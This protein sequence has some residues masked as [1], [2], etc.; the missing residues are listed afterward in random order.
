MVQRI[1]VEHGFE[2]EESVEFNGRRALEI[3]AADSLGF[4]GGRV[5]ETEVDRWSILLDTTEGH[6]RSRDTSLS[7]VLHC[8]F[9]RPSHKVMVKRPYGS[10]AVRS[11]TAI[12]VVDPEA[13]WARN[14]FSRVAVELTRLDPALNLRPVDLLQVGLIRQRRYKRTILH[15]SGVPVYISFDAVTAFDAEGKLALG[16]R[17]WAEAEVIDG[18]PEE[19]M[20]AAQPR[21]VMDYLCTQHGAV[22][23]SASKR[24]WAV[25]LLQSAQWGQPQRASTSVV[26]LSTVSTRAPAASYAAFLRKVVPVGL[27]E[28]PDGPHSYNA[29][30][31]VRDDNFR[32]R[33]HSAHYTV[34]RQHS[35]QAL[36]LLSS[37][38]DQPAVVPMRRAFRTT[39][40]SSAMLRTT[41][42][43]CQRVQPAL[44]AHHAA[45]RHQFAGVYTLA[46]VQVSAYDTAK[47]I[48]F[49]RSREDTIITLDRYFETGRARELFTDG[50]VD[51][52]SGSAH[53]AANTIVGDDGRGW[54]SIPWADTATSTFTLVHECMHALHIDANP[55]YGQL[56]T[57]LRESIA[58]IAEFE[59]FETMEPQHRREQTL[60]R[61]RSQFFRPMYQ[62]AFEID[63]RDNTI[64]RDTEAMRA[65]Y[66]RR[67]SDAYGAAVHISPDDG[68]EWV[69]GRHL[70]RPFALI[71]YATSFLLGALLHTHLNASGDIQPLLHAR[72]IHDISDAINADVTSPATYDRLAEELFMTV[73]RTGNE[74]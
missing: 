27:R 39:A 72:N 13:G 46:D 33:A 25:E 67:L 51:V 68:Y 29:A 61:W 31:A 4:F 18:R 73:V 42:S 11:E 47:P 48:S 28:Y 15:D 38:F 16:E 2:L 32:R 7:V 5:A 9:E 54:V 71:E 45:R 19:M 60:E 22:R 62:T 30:M 12:K 63:L 21:S 53:G 49:E 50:R 65:E 23:S 10:T 40:G 24:S 64:E 34:L 56:P 8:G 74:K 58:R 26:P 17:W 35:Q 59:L 3:A 37:A 55:D 14:V 44:R 57:L 41:A 70:F 52:V 20:R 6:L 69:K 66:V 43:V 1:V 36:T